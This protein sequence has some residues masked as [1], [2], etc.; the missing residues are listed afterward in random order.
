MEDF[1]GLTEALCPNCAQ[2]YLLG[3]NWDK[4]LRWG[5]RRGHIASMAGKESESAYEG[6]LPHVKNTNQQN[7]L[8][9]PFPHTLP[10]NGNV[11]VSTIEE[12]TTPLSR[13]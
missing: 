13:A 7:A 4:L 1:N 12:N 11:G 6:A 10:L 9:L 3:A 8:S 5:L 2:R